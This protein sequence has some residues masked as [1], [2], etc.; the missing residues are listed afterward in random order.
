VHHI[1]KAELKD[2]SA[3]KNLMLEALKEDPTAFSVSFDEYE[4]NTEYWWMS[5]INPFL[6]G[7]SQEMFLN[8]D[9]GSLVGT[10][11]VIYDSKQRKKHIGSFVW[12]Y[13]QKNKR[14]K[15]IGKE[16]IKKALEK[17]ENNKAITKISLLVVA[18]QKEAIEI[19]KK[20]GF[21]INGKLKKE[22]KIG[23]EFLDVLVMEKLL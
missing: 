6:Y 4:P 9:G 19:Y 3:I 11:G 2:Y 16:L 10:I 7:N 17:L 5:Y 13:V 1:Q 15:G 23:S 18:T 20:Y 8:Y 21:E 14:G 22:L 12:F